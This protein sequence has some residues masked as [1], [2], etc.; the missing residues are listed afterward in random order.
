MVKYKIIYYLIDWFIS[1]VFAAIVGI[2]M[3]GKSQFLKWDYRCNY[4]LL[5]LSQRGIRGPHQDTIN[6]G[7]Y[8]ACISNQVSITSSLYK[9]FGPF[10]YAHLR[11]Y[12]ATAPA[13][14]FQWPKFRHQ[15]SSRKFCFLNIFRV[16]STRWIIVWTFRENWKII[17]FTSI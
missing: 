14:Y 2:H 3:Q 5:L 13:Y 6:N 16:L 7:M 15:R 9:Y 1:D 8:N 17:S 11:I 4:Y 10:Q 12:H